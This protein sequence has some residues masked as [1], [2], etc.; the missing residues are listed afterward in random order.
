ME[1]LQNGFVLELCPGAF[2]L[3]TDSMA[4][5]WFA[6]LPKNARVLDLGAGCGTLGLL[7]CARDS[8][9]HVTGVELSPDAHRAALDNIARNGLCGRMESI[10]ADLKTI[11]QTTPPGGFSVCISNPPYFSGGAVRAGQEN[12]RHQGACS[13]EALFESAAWSLKYG[14]DFFLVHKPQALSRLLVQGN[15]H[16]LEGKR[17]CLLRHSPNTLPSLVLLQ[18]RKGAKPGLKLEEVCLREASGELSR[19]YREIYGSS[20]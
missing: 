18:L 15:R 11:P 2:P 17:L 1:I 14:G 3:S 7:L 5:A 19:A 9:C 16:G 20:E 12:A 4:L 10:C 8:S 6:R 13:L